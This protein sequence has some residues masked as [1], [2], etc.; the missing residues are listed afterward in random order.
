MRIT[1]PSTKVNSIHGIDR[2]FSTGNRRNSRGGSVAGS[3]AAAEVID[4]APAAAAQNEA[5][6]P[7][8]PAGMARVIAEG[9]CRMAAAV[10]GAGSALAGTADT[11]PELRACTS[12]E[13][14]A[15]MF[16]PANVKPANN[17]TAPNPM[18]LPRFIG[19]T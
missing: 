5:A 14:T 18:T 16:G 12:A 9:F 11:E 17:V 19:K 2:T 6:S 10:A 4:V 1:V 8:L 3:V 13:A 7:P 15:M